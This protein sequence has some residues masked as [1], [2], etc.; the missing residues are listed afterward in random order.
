MQVYVHYDGTYDDTCEGYPDACK[1]M[2][3]E[4]SCQQQGCTW[5]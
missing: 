2:N 3:S 5:E 1:E 4:G